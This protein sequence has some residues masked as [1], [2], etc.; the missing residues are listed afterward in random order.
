MYI[1]KQVTF[2]TKRL[3]AGQALI[4]HLSLELVPYHNVI[5]LNECSPEQFETTNMRNA[6]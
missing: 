3:Y 5:Q 2:N 1:V 6:T 4:D